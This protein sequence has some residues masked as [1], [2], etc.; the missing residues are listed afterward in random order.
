MMP[1]AGKYV[2]ADLL[3]V[4]NCAT[5]C[6]ALLVLSGLVPCSFQTSSGKCERMSFSSS[7]DLELGDPCSV[8]AHTAEQNNVGNHNHH[9]AE[10]G[11]TDSRGNSEA[12][13]ISGEASD[14]QGEVGSKQLGASAANQTRGN[15]WALHFFWTQSQAP[16]CHQPR[17]LKSIPCNT[18]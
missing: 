16:C 6:A 4:C 5:S 12:A 3:H 9:S 13:G 1:E 8:Q 2:I 11:R 18:F 17:G 10:H 15:S 7:D 14:S